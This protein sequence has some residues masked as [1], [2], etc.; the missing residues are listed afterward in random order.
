M[1]IVRSRFVS[2]VASAALIWTWKRAAQLLLI[3]V[4][5]FAASAAF[6]GLFHQLAW[7][8]TDSGPLTRH[9][10]KNPD[11]FTSPE[12]L[13][14]MRMVFRYYA[15]RH[16]RHPPDG[17][18]PDPKPASHSWQTRILPFLKTDVMVD[19]Q[20][21]WDDPKNAPIFQRFVSDYLSPA[22]GVLRDSR[23]FAVSHYAGN[24]RLFARPC[25]ITT[26][27]LFNGISKTIV[28]GEVVADFNAWGDPANLRDLAEGV[29]QTA[30]GFGSTDERGAKFLMLDGS[31]LF[32]STGTDP[33]VL[34]ELSG[35]LSIT[36]G[37]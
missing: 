18:A 9:R 29:N 37:F 33:L 7:L 35:N 17:T 34:A 22:T 19:W 15:D 25:R 2:F 31:V 24:S 26:E 11:R 23:G 12:E 20:H 3:V 14:Q 27:S 8:G 4:L 28:C 5:L 36:D 13:Q 6:V 10:L 21:D 30:A 1:R 32:L 16:G